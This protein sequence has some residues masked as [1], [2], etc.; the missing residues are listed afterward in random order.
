[1]MPQPINPLL[2]SSNADGLEKQPAPTGEKDNV[3]MGL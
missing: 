3:S 2:V 1:M